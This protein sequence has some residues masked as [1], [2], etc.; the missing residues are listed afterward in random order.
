MNQPFIDQDIGLRIGTKDVHSIIL[1]GLNSELPEFGPALDARTKTIVAVRTF[2]KRVAE[3]K[4]SRMVTD[5]ERATMRVKAAD[6]VF[7]VID[8]VRSKTLPLLSQSIDSRE[9]QLKPWMPP[10]E[11]ADFGTDFKFAER[12]AAMDEAAFSSFVEG[13][14]KY[15]TVS[16][17]ADAALRLGLEFSGLTGERWARI[18]GAKNLALNGAALQAIA[19]VTTM[20]DRLAKTTDA[21]EHAMKQEV[22][23]DRA[24]ALHAA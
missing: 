23:L 1:D 22:A 24:G 7:S 20:R 15:A 16:R 11:G 10:T 3:I 17:A 14:G 21:L 12:V 6:Q 18:A 4:A 19:D 9:R 13:I 5:N 8:E 2:N